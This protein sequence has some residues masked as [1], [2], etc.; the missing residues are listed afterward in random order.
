MTTAPS[1]LPY[2]PATA[3][4]AF[5]GPPAV[6]LALLEP[7]LADLAAVVR[8]PSPPQARLPTPCERFDVT[9]LR[10]HVL[11]WLQFFAA[12]LADPRCEQP[13]PDPD[14]YR[15]A[16]DDR[17][18]ADA[19]RAAAGAGPG[20]RRRGGGAVGGGGGQDRGRPPRGRPRVL[21]D[22]RWRRPRDDPR[23]V[24]RARV[25]PGARARPAVVAG[26]GGVRGG[27]RVL[28]G[29]D[30]A[31]VPRWRR[32]LLRAGGAR[33]RRGGRLRAAVG[34]RRPR[35]AVAGGPLTRHAGHEIHACMTSPAVG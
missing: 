17:D 9:A 8:R 19:V 3:P 2:F 6:A 24:P 31:G 5:S 22:G 33:G 18:P 28:P 35:P 14:A 7:V 21:P 16:Q 11:G 29:D 32:R 30:R 12:A 23:G 25:G 34:V 15:A 26:A 4:A 27:A 13:R 10:D 1:H 20:G